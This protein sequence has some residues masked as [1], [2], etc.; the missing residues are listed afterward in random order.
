PYPI[1]QAA[2]DRFQALVEVGQAPTFDP[3][4]DEES[5][6][7]AG[8]RNDGIDRDT[9][10]LAGDASIGSEIVSLSSEDGDP[11]RVEGAISNTI[12]FAELTSETD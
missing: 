7:S 9:A 8:V 11:A 3:V 1:L 6:E 4:L 2:S 10:H 12:E 5:S